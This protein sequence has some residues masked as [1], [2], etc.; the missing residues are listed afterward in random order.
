ME[1]ALAP[2]L[3]QNVVVERLVLLGI[4]HALLERLVA[5]LDVL[6]VLG[7][8]ARIH[9]RVA[10]VAHTDVEAQSG[11]TKVRLARPNLLVAAGA[12]QQRRLHRQID[13]KARRAADLPLRDIDAFQHGTRV[14]FLAHCGQVARLG[15]PRGIFGP[16]RVTAAHE[17]HIARAIFV[18][19]RHHGCVR[20][21]RR[22]VS[23]E[24]I[25]LSRLGA[26]RLP[27]R[28]DDDIHADGDALLVAVGRL[29]PDRY[30]RAVL[31]ELG[32][33]ALLGE[34]VEADEIDVAILPRPVRH[35]IR[36]ATKGL[37][38]ALLLAR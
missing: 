23:L 11:V 20:L 36:G 14:A 26:A 1:P 22:R 4:P 35:G 27:G 28:V 31:D 32:H 5:Q 8:R 38:V 13:V 9:V 33:L 17:L 15:T 25:E 37:L 34:V 30:A 2:T 18:H 21:Q 16:A 19:G 7:L 10:P 3:A 24:G 29:M 12:A 6:E